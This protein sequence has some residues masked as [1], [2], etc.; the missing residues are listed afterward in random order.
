MTGEGDVKDVTK[1]KGKLAHYLKISDE[2]KTLQ[3]KIRLITL[4]LL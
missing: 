4:R 2:D 3:S 1:C